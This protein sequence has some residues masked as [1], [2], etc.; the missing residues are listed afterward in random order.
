MANFFCQ[1]RC[2]PNNQEVI[3]TYNGNIMNYHFCLLIFIQFDLNALLLLNFK[4]TTK[5][6]HL[7]LIKR[8]D[9]KFIGKFEK[10]KG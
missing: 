5:H 7:A 4:S 1:T 10:E 9:D 3:A 2:H 6:D 8:L